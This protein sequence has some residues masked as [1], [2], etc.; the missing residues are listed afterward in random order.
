MIDSLNTVFK[1]YEL[2]S[3]HYPMAENIVNE[4]N[5]NLSLIRY[6]PT[7]TLPDYTHL[8][9]EEWE[10]KI[11]QL[12]DEGKI[13]YPDGTEGETEAERI[14]NYASYLKSNFGIEYPMNAL[15]DE[16]K[17]LDEDVANFMENH[18]PEGNEDQMKSL[19]SFR[20]SS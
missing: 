8:T 10:E 19:L 20:I 6:S 14:A 4:M 17:E 5:S 11:Q 13:G 2:T 9:L 3:T 15:A 16:L 1:S 12:I 7:K 18:K